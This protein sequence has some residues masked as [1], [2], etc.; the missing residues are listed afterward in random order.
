MSKYNKN[1]K[2]FRQFLDGV[3][4]TLAKI[5]G[6]E[7]WNYKSVLLHLHNSTQMRRDIVLLIMT[8]SRSCHA[9]LTSTEA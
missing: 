1:K 3:G 9:N 6:N 7:E 8:V 4:G 5:T 2:N